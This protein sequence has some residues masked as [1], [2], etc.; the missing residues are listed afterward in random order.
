MLKCEIVENHESLHKILKYDFYS[1]WY[2]PSNGI[3]AN[4]ALW[5][6]PKFS[7]STFSSGYFD[8]RTLKMQTLQLPSNRKLDICHQIT[9]LQLLYIVTLIYIFKV[10]NCAMWISR[11]WWASEKC[12]SMTFIEVDIWYRMGPLR[13]WPLPKF[14][15]SNLKH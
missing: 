7:R 14:S 15:R 3:I 8:K 11:K 6:W 12:S 9:Q 13:M 1:C 4:V 5:R 10:M 2:V